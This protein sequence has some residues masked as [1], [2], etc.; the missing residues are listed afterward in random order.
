MSDVRRADYLAL[1]EGTPWLNWI[2]LTK[3]PQVAAKFLRGRKVP[4]N[5]WP[6]I[7]AETQKMLDLRAPVICS[8]PATVHVLSAQPWLG[9]LNAQRFLGHGKHQLSWV[10]AGGES[11]PRAP[12]SHPAW[13]RTLRDH[14]ASAGVPFFFKQ[15]GEWAPDGEDA[16]G[17]RRHHD[18][19]MPA[20]QRNAEN[21][22]PRR[23]GRN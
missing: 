16:P 13:F 6:G 19:A 5:L 21:R 4:A 10:I 2:R 20:P 11:D 1:I 9:A 7:T 23:R 15:W 18:W 12:P 17:G 14:C 22:T 8:I 3:R